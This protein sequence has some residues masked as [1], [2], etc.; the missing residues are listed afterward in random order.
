MKQRQKIS[1]WQLTREYAGELQR[2]DWTE[3]FNKSFLGL[4]I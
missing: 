4:M 2:N 1:P 3:V